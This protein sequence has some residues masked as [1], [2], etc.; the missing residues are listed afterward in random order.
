[1][2]K[3]IAAAALLLFAHGCVSATRGIKRVRHGPPTLQAY[4]TGSGPDYACTWT[5]GNQYIRVPVPESKV[6]DLAA[7]KNSIGAEY[8]WWLENALAIDW[9]ATGDRLKDWSIPAIDKATCMP[10]AQSAPTHR[11]SLAPPLQAGSAS[12]APSSRVAME[13]AGADQGLSAVV[14]VYVCAQVDLLD[15]RCAALP[16]PELCAGIE[17]ISANC[18]E[19]P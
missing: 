9:V 8:N 18:P 3:T 1:M 13:S 2:K 19:A 7:M 4:K 16:T 14:L 12:A 5:R 15:A 11:F 10:A 6:H 17:E